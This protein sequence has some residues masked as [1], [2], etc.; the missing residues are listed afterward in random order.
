M[1]FVSLDL[2]EISNSPVPLN[3]KHYGNGPPLIIIHG[4][5]GS[6]ANWSGIGKRL[7]DRFS[8]FVLDLRNHGEST[9]SSNFGYRVL[10]EDLKCFM[11]QQHIFDA[12]IL[13][14]SIGGKIAMAFSDSC[15]EMINK[16]IVVDIAPKSYPTGNKYILKSL[17]DLDVSLI[18]NIREAVEALA[19]A[20]PSLTIRYFLV[21]NLVR[22]DD[23]RYRWKINLE[24][25]QR[26]YEE[27]SRGP[28]IKTLFAKPTLFIRGENSNYIVPED[29][30]LIQRYFQKW[31]IVTIKNVGHWLHIDAPGETCMAIH[32]F[33]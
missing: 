8:V 11:H 21:K 1:Q 14:H 2:Y 17:I 4:L 3:F 24:A 12:T 13:G 33:L 16:L 31:E 6:Q 10:V 32:K 22:S 26:H 15:P 27:L 9:H 29:S 18:S 5:F 7:S 19:P 30:A 20:I 28:R 25:I 23:R